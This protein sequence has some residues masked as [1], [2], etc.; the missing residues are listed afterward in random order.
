MLLALNNEMINNNTK[1]FV[2]DFTLV[3]ML[4]SLNVATF[5]YIFLRRKIS[6]AI[7]NLSRIFPLFLDAITE[8]YIPVSL[9]YYRIL[10]HYISL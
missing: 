4:N 9:G 1:V 3:A 5:Y 7:E 2:V 6:F 8:N 10:F